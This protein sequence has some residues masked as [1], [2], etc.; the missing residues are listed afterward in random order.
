D[1][2]RYGYPLPDG[3]LADVIEKLEENQ[4]R[5]LGLD[6]FRDRPVKTGHAA[7]MRQFQQNQRLIGLCSVRE[8]NNPNKPTIAPPP[9]L[10]PDRLGYS[11]LVVDPDGIIRRH[12][13]FM[14][15]SLNDACATNY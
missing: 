4:P 14:Q 6:I 1:V 5:V 13:M 10:S 8:A 2:N 7:L 11:D 15:P 9:G 3:I 12:L